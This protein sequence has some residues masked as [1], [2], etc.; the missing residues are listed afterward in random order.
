MYCF[1]VPLLLGFACNAA[2]AFTT[3]FS[4]RWGERA[5]R[6]A[7]FVLRDL[8]GIPLWVFGL[9]LAVRTPAPPLFTPSFITG[10]LGWLLVI[11]GAAL[12]WAALLN[13]GWRA[14]APTTGD[15]LEAH[16]IYRH[17]R[18]PIYSGLSLEFAGILL[19]QPTYPVLLAASL[20]I[21]WVLIQAR[22]EELDLLQRMPAYQEYMQRVP[23]FL[24]RLH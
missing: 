10:L 23:G 4:R 6:A 21:A 11:G 19:I 22:L 24:P 12:I 8:L 5:S 15:M 13:L 17:I 16:G 9:V 2:S 1:L 18:H 3:A 7:T 14:A 20:G